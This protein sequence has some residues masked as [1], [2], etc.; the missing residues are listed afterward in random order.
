MMHMKEIILDFTLNDHGFDS[1]F[2]FVSWDW[3]LISIF[4]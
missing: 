1:S 2:G 3:P 4:L